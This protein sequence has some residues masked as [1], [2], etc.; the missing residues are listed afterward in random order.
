MV[1]LGAWQSHAAG[2]RTALNP[3]ALT[4]LIS[5]CETTG[6]P[7]AVSPHWASIVLPMFHPRLIWLATCCA[8]GSCAWAG[9]ETKYAEKD[10]SIA[11]NAT[12]RHF[13]A[14]GLRVDMGSPLIGSNRRPDYA[15]AG[16]GRA[17][18]LSAAGI[19]RLV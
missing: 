6:L 12:L 13:A 1:P 17:I 15:R 16:R 5:V 18:R 8:V 2:M 9:A 11:R 10:A 7:Q 19:S 3:A 4:A 14:E